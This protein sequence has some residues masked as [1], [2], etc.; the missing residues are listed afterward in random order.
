MSSELEVKE[1]L[2]EEYD[3]NLELLTLAEKEGA[4]ETAKRIRRKLRT[5]KLKLHPLELP[6]NIDE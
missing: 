4:T 6:D 2:I 1:R 5:I 3:Y